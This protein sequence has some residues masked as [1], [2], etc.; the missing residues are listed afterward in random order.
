MMGQP[1]PRVFGKP[2]RARRRFVGPRIGFVAFMALAGAGLLWTLQGPRFSGE[3]RLR[4]SPALLNLGRGERRSPSSSDAAPL[5]NRDFSGAKDDENT[6]DDMVLISGGRFWM[7]ASLGADDEWPRHE[8]ELDRF[9]IDVHEVTRS[10]YSRFVAATGYATTAERAG[11]SWVFDGAA[12]HWRPTRG[13]SW[14][15]PNGHDTAALDEP[16]TQVSWSDAQAF[17]KWRGKRLPTEAEWECA[18]AGGLAD[19]DY[20]WGRDLRTEGRYEANYWQ[21]WFPDRD[22]GSD[23]FTGVAP[24]RWFRANRFGLHDMAGNVWEWC[25]DW[26]ASDYYQY[27]PT[28]NPRGPAQGEARSSTRR[29][30]AERRRT[31]AAGSRCMRDHLA[32]GV[33]REDIGFRCARDAQP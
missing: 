31:R 33:A 10:E 18:A 30:L 20:P 23:G 8:T 1:A 14:R 5:D 28:R 16:V 2:A 17:A 3:S 12:R 32:P 29:I 22:L 26:H 11:Y 15:M 6:P 21:G 25:A 19:A 24:V 4:I 9:W 13:A 7:G 27:A